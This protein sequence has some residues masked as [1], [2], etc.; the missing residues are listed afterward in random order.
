[1]TTTYLA[2]AVLQQLDHAQAELDRHLA[3]R[4]DG[5]CMACLQPE[6]CPA[7]ITANATLVRYG[8]LPRRRP[9]LAH[10]EAGRVESGGSRFGWF[11][12]ATSGGSR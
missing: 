9:G 4:A 5:R 8:R 6:P 1:V 10:V 3:T 2:S 11:T 12:D 7:R